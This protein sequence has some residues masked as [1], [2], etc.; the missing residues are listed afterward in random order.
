MWR[1]RVENTLFHEF[2]YSRSGALVTPDAVKPA[3]KI[4]DMRNEYSTLLGETP[5]V[6]WETDRTAGVKGGVTI[7]MKSLQTNQGRRE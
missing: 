5:A 4:V 3:Q 7:A 2:F 1:Y 6:S